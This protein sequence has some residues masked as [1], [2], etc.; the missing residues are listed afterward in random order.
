MVRAFAADSGEV[1]WTI[2][3]GHRIGDVRD[4]ILV[5]KDDESAFDEDAQ[6]VLPAD[7]ILYVRADA[8]VVALLCK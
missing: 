5:G 6:A 2:T 3:T 1:R 4:D 8:G 7:G